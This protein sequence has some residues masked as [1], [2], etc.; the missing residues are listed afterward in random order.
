MKYFFSL[1]LLLSV[2]SHPVFAKPPQPIK[3]QKGESTSKIETGLV[4]GETK[5]YS[6]GAKE[7]QSMVVTIASY[8]NNAVFQIHG[9]DGNDLTEENNETRQ[10]EESLPETGKYIIQVSS[11]RGNADFVL[12]VS[13]Q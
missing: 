2:L 7:G 12:L 10:W 4:R 5:E 1:I 3:F 8:E 9:P 11:L 6:V 13:I